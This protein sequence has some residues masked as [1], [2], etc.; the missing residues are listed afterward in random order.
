MI[1]YG[2]G[3]NWRYTQDSG[4]GQCT[5]LYLYDWLVQIKECQAFT[6]ATATNPTPM[7]GNMP[8]I[9][10]RK[11]PISNIAWKTQRISATSEL[12]TPNSDVGAFRVSCLYSHMNFDDPIVYPGQ[13]G[14]SHLHTFYGNSNTDAFSTVGTLAET[15]GSSCDG[16]TM[17]RSA[18]WVPSMI[19][20]ASGTPIASGRLGVY[21]KSGYYGIKP[22][23]VNLLPTGLRMITGNSKG[24]SAQTSQATYFECTNVPSGVTA[25][26]RSKSIP[27]CPI[28]ST[29]HMSIDFPQCWDGLNLDS[30]D[31]R[32]HMSFPTNGACPNT[33][34]VP[35]PLISYNLNYPV[36]EANAPLRWR[37]AS[38]NYPVDLPGGYS[39]HADW[40]DG[41]DPEIMKSWVKNCIQ[42]DKDCHANLLG[43]GRYFY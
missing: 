36:K 11:I 4:T 10:K 8:S 20:T 18:Y 3:S 13:P 19:D 21:Y 1:R 37:L 30:P 15:G 22:S 34:P 35:I 33:H 28:G 25:P 27:N 17:N 7:A 32:S 23:D 43:D 9:D 31:H 24:Y 2:D 5:A 16:G 38:D 29:V 26:A 40:M 39:A 6:P 12:P 41:W 42:A 14:L